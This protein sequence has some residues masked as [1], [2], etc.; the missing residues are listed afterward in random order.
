MYRTADGN[1]GGRVGFI[2]AR[3]SIIA[4]LIVFFEIPETKGLRV[5]E[6]NARFE[7]RLPTRAFQQTAIVQA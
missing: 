6:L 7:Q 4:L 5:E 1:W 2:F 3:V